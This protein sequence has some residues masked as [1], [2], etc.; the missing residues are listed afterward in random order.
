MSP[1]GGDLPQ[2]IL[3]ERGGFTE[4]AASLGVRGCRVCLRSIQ[5][6][7]ELFCR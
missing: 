2:S 7:N 1:C 4:D 6:L 3:D 5:D